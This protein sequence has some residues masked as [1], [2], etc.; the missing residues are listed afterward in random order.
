MGQTKSYIDDDGEA[1][2]LDDAWFKE[3]KRG[4]PE[5]PSAKRK[6][7]VNV[8]LDPEVA[9]RLRQEENM[10]AYANAALRKALGL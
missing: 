10:S 2:E 6:Q 7:R 1:L 9:E 4:R 8:M 3:A 5:L